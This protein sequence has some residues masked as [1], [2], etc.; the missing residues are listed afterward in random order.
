MPARRIARAAAGLAA[1][2]AVWWL[3][4][5]GSGID[6]VRPLPVARWKSSWRS[7][8]SPID[9]Y[10]NAR[11]HEHVAA[12]RDA[13]DDGLRVASSFGV[14]LGLAMGASR[15]VE[16]FVNPIFL[17][18]RPIPPLAWIPLAIVWLG[19]GR[20]GQDHG[21][22]RRRVRAVGDQ[23]LQRRAPDRPRRSSKPARCSTSRAGATGARCWSRAR[24]PASSRACACR[25][26]LRGPRWWPPNWSARRP[27]SGRS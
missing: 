23:Q 9:G 8:R 12:Q 27:A 7:A 1:L 16:A 4:T 11:W 10:S 24:C 2:I 22:L 6:R 14:A 19:P 5:A 3:L 17:F 15:K 13:G 18:L 26:R 20:R 25:C 21:D